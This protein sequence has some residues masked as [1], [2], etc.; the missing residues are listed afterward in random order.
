M[1]PATRP[2]RIGIDAHIVGAGKGGVERFLREICLRLPRLL[3]QHR[4]VVFC[5]AAAIENDVFAAADP[6]VQLVALP[7]ANP[8]IERALVLPWL[9]RR[10]S[11]DALLVQRIAPWAMGQC[12]IVTTIHDIT[13]IKFA[14]QYRGLTN[15]L[16]RR[17]TAPSARRSA[18]V[19]TPTEVIGREVAALSGAPASRFKAYYNGVDTGMFRPSTNHDEPGAVLSSFALGAPFVFTSG[20]LER[21]KNVE[22]M[23]RAVRRLPVE[24]C[25]HLVISGAT[26]DARYACELQALASD[27]DSDVPGRIRFLG[28]VNDDDL[29]CLYRTAAAFISASRDEGFNMPVLEAMASGVPTLASDIAVHRELFEG[30]TVFFPP[31]DDEALAAAL[32]R[33]LTQCVERDELVAAG[34]E[35][36]GRYSWEAA[37]RRVGEGLEEACRGSAAR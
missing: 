33:V 5:N 30:A 13:P 3:A 35:R 6:Q 2:L 25:R 7:F 34:R 18:V 27:C 28:F 19:L 37:A 21:R 29:T 36:A 24:L 32:H 14:P 4:Y 12:R 22:T 31:D 10:H 16:I 11:L 15:A 17:L 1:T 23:I 9:A 26:R 20:A 8:L